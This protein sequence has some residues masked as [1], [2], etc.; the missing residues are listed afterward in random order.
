MINV[1]NASLTTRLNDLKSQHIADEVKKVNNKV[2]KK[3]SDILGFESRL[4]LKEDLTNE[5]E[6][7]ASFKGEN[8]YYYNQQ[9]YILFEPKSKSYSR[10]GGVVNSW[11]LTVI[12]NDSKNTDLFSIGYSI[13]ILLKLINQNNRLGVNFQEDYMKQNK[14]GYAHGSGLDIYIVYE[15]SSPHFTAENCLFGAVKITKDVNISH[16]KYS[17]YGICFNASDFSIDNFTDGKNVIIFGA[18]MSFSSTQQIDSII[19]MF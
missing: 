5:L 1:S 8:Y 4:K 16:Y 9:S 6:R 2:S 10:N 13:S 19:F 3:S 11:I 7:E 18:D 12:H 17:G 14:V 15:L